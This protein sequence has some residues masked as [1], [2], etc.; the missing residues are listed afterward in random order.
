[1]KKLRS[2]L[3]LC[4]LAMTLFASTALADITI[5]TNDTTDAD[6][7]ELLRIIEEGSGVKIEAITSPSNPD[8]RVAKFTTILASG[9]SSVD[10][11]NIN[12]EMITQYM[13]AGFLAPLENDVMRPE[14]AAHNAE[15]QY[16]MCVNQA[17][18]PYLSEEFKT[19]TV[20]NVRGELLVDAEFMEEVGATETTYQEI[21]TAFK[22]Q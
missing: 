22:N 6:W 1:M 16:Y 7:N 18:E 20:R 13:A 4:C 3:L 10:L 14:V 2:V 9:D 11:L 8:D 15:M 19:A 12:D 5:M 17:A 21:Y